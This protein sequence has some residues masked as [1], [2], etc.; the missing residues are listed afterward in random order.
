VP[1]NVNIETKMSIVLE[2]GRGEEPR[3]NDDA[4]TALVGTIYSASGLLDVATSFL[5]LLSTVV[6]LSHPVS[7]ISLTAPPPAAAAA[8]SY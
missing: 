1:C 4:F 2:D 7:E 8:A 5:A 3:M 6:C